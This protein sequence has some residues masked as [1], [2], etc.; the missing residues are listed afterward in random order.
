MPDLLVSIIVH[1]LLLIGKIRRNDLLIGNA[2]Q[3]FE[4]IWGCLDWTLYFSV[5]ATLNCLSLLIVTISLPHEKIYSDYFSGKSNVF[6]TSRAFHISSPHGP[7]L[8]I[9]YIILSVP[10]GRSVRAVACVLFENRHDFYALT[11][12]Q[13]LHQ[14]L[15]TFRFFFP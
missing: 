10:Q 12:N 6:Q 8:V 5:L 13:I 2:D 4:S 3:L 15:G 14:M 9:F 7:P 11:S 1:S